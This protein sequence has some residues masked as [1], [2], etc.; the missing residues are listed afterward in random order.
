MT[1]QERKIHVL[2][3]CK[4]DLERLHGYHELLGS[5]LNHFKDKIDGTELINE[6]ECDL[7]SSQI[8]A[9]ENENYNIGKHLDFM[10]SKICSI[11]RRESEL[12]V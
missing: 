11:L 12:K 4:K 8:L 2:E 9:V 7:V 10:N 1:D 6:N 5:M 3:Q